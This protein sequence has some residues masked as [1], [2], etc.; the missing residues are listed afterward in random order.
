MG[1][2]VLHPGF[3]NIAHKIDLGEMRATRGKCAKIGIFMWYKSCFYIDFF[4]ILWHDIEE[5]GFVPCSLELVK[6][7]FAKR[8]EELW[9]ARSSES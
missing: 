9:Q 7:V 5:H 1:L 4:T 8:V 2:F 3:L 6:T